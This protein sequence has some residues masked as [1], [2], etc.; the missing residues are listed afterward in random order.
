MKM[1]MKKKM[2][3]AHTVLYLNNCIREDLY[4]ILREMTQQVTESERS[5]FTIDWN[6]TLH[7]QT[8][9]YINYTVGN[10]LGWHI[11]V[12]G[13]VLT[14]VIMLSKPNEDFS[15]GE[16]E[17]MDSQYLMDRIHRNIEDFDF[18]EYSVGLNWHQGDFVVFPITSAHRVKEVLSGY[19]SSFV[20]EFRYGITSKL[21]SKLKYHLND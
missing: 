9:E 5:Y 20:V 12:G 1:K 14:L 7:A 8:I 3:A 13:T 6:E 16:L 18:S 2:E 19:R 15:G 21:H 17:F 4:N 10:S 11:D